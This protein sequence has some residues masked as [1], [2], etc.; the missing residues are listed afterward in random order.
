MLNWH[1]QRNSPSPFGSVGG[2][3]VPGAFTAAMWS[4]AN[5]ATATAGGTLDVTISSLPGANGSAITDIEYEIGGSGTWLS[6]GGVSD[7]KITGLTNGSAYAIRIRAVNG[8][9]SAG[10]S[11]SKSATPQD[12]VD[13]VIGTTT[14]NTSTSEIDVSTVSEAGQYFALVNY[15]ATALTG[16]DIESQVAAGTPD[17][18]VGPVSLSSGANTVSIDLSGVTAGTAYLHQTVKDAAGNYSTDVPVQFTQPAGGGSTPAFKGDAYNSTAATSHTFN[19]TSTGETALPATIAAGKYVVLVMTKD[20]VPT[21]VTVDGTAATLK[22]SVATADRT[23]SA[24]EVTT[25]GSG[26]NNIVVSIGVSEIC[27]A[28]LFDVG[29]KAFATGIAF[30]RQIGTTTFPIND[31]GTTS[32]TTQSGDLVMTICAT[33]DT[34]PAGWVGLTQVKAYQTLGARGY[35]AA[36][37]N[38]AAGGAPE[39]LSLT[40]SAAWKYTAVA[41]VVYR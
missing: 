22:H 39:S 31:D 8:V 37:A 12:V 7:F 1:N 34:A 27:A 30:D 28:I 14:V 21:G 29:S 25:T 5:D 20:T 35:L 16:A 15:S 3:S 41:T 11:D 9:G 18:E 13:P 17:A 36:W 10:P 4:L 6:S 26:V 32:L 2:A 33:V 38:P 19:S 23:V 40:T 24:W